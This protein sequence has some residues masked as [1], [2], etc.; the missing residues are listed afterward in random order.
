MPFFVYIQFSQVVCIGLLF[1]DS[2]Q[3]NFENKGNLKNAEVTSSEYN[4]YTL[5]Y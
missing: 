4:G 3:I 1:Q 5:Y 2:K